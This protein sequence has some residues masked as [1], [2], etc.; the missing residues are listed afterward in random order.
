MSDAEEGGYEPTD[1]QNDEE[2][3]TPTEE[4]EYAEEEYAE[5]EA[6]EE[7]QEAGADQEEQRSF[8]PLSDQHTPDFSPSMNKI[9]P[10]DYRA[11]I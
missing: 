11:I 10:R 9:S 6:A 8:L 5:E 7:E 4:G 3:I 2:D 1:D